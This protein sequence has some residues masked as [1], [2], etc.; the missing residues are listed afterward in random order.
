MAT[1]SFRDFDETVSFVDKFL[2]ILDKGNVDTYVFDSKYLYEIPNF[3][4]LQY[5]NS[6]YSATIDGLNNFIDKVDEVLKNSNN[7]IRSLKNIE[8]CLCVI[9][10]FDKFVSSLTPE[11]KQKFINLLAKSKESLK[12][13]FIFIDIPAGFKPYEFE[14]WYKS[15]IDSSTGL[16]IGDGFAEQYLIKPTKIIQDY[17]DVIGNNYGYIVDK[18]QVKFIKIIEKI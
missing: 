3:T 9:I 16:W 7:N 8:E 12:I 5:L 17:Y 13:H 14:S 4:K 2:H 18:G 6:N 11:Y 1:L 10:G 15:A